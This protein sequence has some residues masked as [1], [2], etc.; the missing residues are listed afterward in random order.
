MMET[1]VLYL[2]RSV[3]SEIPYEDSLLKLSHIPVVAIIQ[4]KLK[5]STR[6]QK[7]KK[8]KLQP[9]EVKQ[10]NFDYVLLNSDSLISH[11]LDINLDFPIDPDV[12]SELLAAV[13]IKNVN[14]IN[15][16]INRI[17]KETDIFSISFVYKGRQMRV[18]KYGVVEIDG[19]Y[20]ELTELALNSPV[21]IITGIRNTS[22]GWVH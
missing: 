21:G 8:Y 7:V 22:N 16:C 13:K 15:E 1:F 20:E 19:E 11:I 5:T 2:Y 17:R 18:S 10:S 6:L 14:L 4:N 3:I 9:Y 12:K